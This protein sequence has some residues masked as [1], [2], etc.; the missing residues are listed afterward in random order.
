MTLLEERGLPYAVAINEF[1]G[2]PMFPEEELR[3][4][5]DLLPTTPL[6]TC[7]ARDPVSSTQALIALVE[8]LIET[9]K[10]ESA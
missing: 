2:A 3:E 7:D 8:Y 5:L 10:R 6:V 4:A 9:K 1:D